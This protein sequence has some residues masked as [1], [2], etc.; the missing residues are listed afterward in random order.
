MKSNNDLFFVSHIPKYAGTRSIQIRKREYFRSTSY[1]FAKIKIIASTLTHHKI[2][3]IKA[4]AARIIISKRKYKWVFIIGCY[5][6][7]TTLLDEILRQHP[8]IAGLPDEGQFL[9]KEFIT[10]RGVGVPRLW[11]EKENIFAIAPDEKKE[12]AKNVLKDWQNRISKVKAKFILEK[13][14]TNIA[15][16]L[17]LQ[18]NFP[19]AHFI[20]IVRNGYAVALGIEKKVTAVYGNKENLLQRAAS[21]WKRSAEIFRK[22]SVSLEKVIEISYE[23]L[24]ENPEKTIEEI[25]EFLHISPLKKNILD[26]NFS[27]HEMNKEIQNQNPIRL[28][29][30]TIE[31]KQIIELEAEAMLRYFRYK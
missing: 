30:M 19:N 22:D 31:Q 12:S 16:L 27:I 11:T 21:Q 15:R 26:R 28:K 1:K 3:R 13:S 5:N 24:T 17:W 4:I 10:P 7:G 2:N 14:P 29:K 25:T 18:N 9:T 23:E 6:S 8:K 20:H